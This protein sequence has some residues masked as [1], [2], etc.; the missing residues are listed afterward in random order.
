MTPKS[1]FEINW[2]LTLMNFMQFKDLVYKKNNYSNE[3]WNGVNCH[4]SEYRSGPSRRTGKKVK[5]CKEYLAY[6]NSLT[7]PI[8]FWNLKSCNARTWCI[9]KLIIPVRIEMASTA[10]EVKGYSEKEWQIIP[11]VGKQQLRT[12]RSLNRE[13][14]TRLLIFRKFYI[15]FMSFT[16]V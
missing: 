13:G 4:W 1:P 9:R 8:L 6:A 11:K 10:I 7:Y 15:F 3:Y 16:G 14:Y 5:L 12:F 2:P